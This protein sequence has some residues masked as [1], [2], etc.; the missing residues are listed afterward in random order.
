MTYPIDVEK[1]EDVLKWQDGQLTDW[2]QVLGSKLSIK[3]QEGSPERRG[4]NGAFSIDLFSVLRDLYLTQDEPNDQVLLHLNAIIDIL[5]DAPS[6][7]RTQSLNETVMIEGE[8]L[9]RQTSY[10]NTL[11]RLQEIR[12]TMT[13]ANPPYATPQ[14]I[15][16]L[17]VNIRELYQI[18]TQILAELTQNGLSDNFFR[19]IC[20]K[21]LAETHGAFVRSYTQAVQLARKFI[22][23]FDVYA[24]LSLLSASFQHPCKYKL[25]LER[26]YKFCNDEKKEKLNHIISQLNSLI[27]NVDSQIQYEDTF[28]TTITLADQYNLPVLLENNRRVCQT[29]E[30]KHY[31]NEL[32]MVDVSIILCNDILIIQSTNS[33]FSDRYPI[34]LDLLH[35]EIKVSGNGRL[36]VVLNLNPGIHDEYQHRTSLLHHYRMMKIRTARAVAWEHGIGRVRDILNKEM[37]CIPVSPK[38]LETNQVSVSEE[39]RIVDLGCSLL[40]VDQYSTYRLMIGVQDVKYSYWKKYSGSLSQSLRP[41][42][43][44]YFCEELNKL[45]LLGP[46]LRIW[47]LNEGRIEWEIPTPFEQLVVVGDSLLAFHERNKFFSVSNICLSDRHPSWKEKKSKDPPPYL[48]GS[49]AVRYSKYVL[50]IGGQNSDGQWMNTIHVYDILTK[51]WSLWYPFGPEEMP[52]FRHHQAEISGNFLYIILETFIYVLN[53]DTLFWCRL[54]HTIEEDQKVA[55]DGDGFLF[56]LQREDNG[57]ITLNRM[58][59][60]TTRIRSVEGDRKTSNPFA[61]PVSDIIDA[62]LKA[63]ETEDLYQ[64]FLMCFRLFCPAVTLMR[65]LFQ[66]HKRLVETYRK[67]ESFIGSQ[68]HGAEEV[69]TLTLHTQVCN[70]IKKWF[71]RFPSDFEIPEVK[72]MYETMC[73]TK[74]GNYRVEF[75]IVPREMNKIHSIRSRSMGYLPYQDQYRYSYEKVNVTNKLPSACVIDTT[76]ANQFAQQMAFNHFQLL[77]QIDLRNLI[78]GKEDHAL[79]VLSERSGQI[80]KWVERTLGGDNFDMKKGADQF[81]HLVRIGE[82]SRRVRDYHTLRSLITSMD[83]ILTR[84]G[85]REFQNKR[86]SDSGKTGKRKLSKKSSMAKILSKKVLL[87]FS[88]MSDLVWSDKALFQE[89]ES[90]P[91]PLIP[92]SSIIK[93]KLE[94]LSGHQFLN[95]GVNYGIC[96]NMTQFLRRIADSRSRDYEFDFDEIWDL[97][98][99]FFQF[100]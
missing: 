23:H 88:E 15:S 26:Y 45:L 7:P 86:F 75:L 66:R 73:N 20:R 36:L 37:L 28:R 30:G 90:A 91:L 71:R 96:R 5:D 70:L 55:P 92:P 74:I 16:C 60:D 44:C 21:E 2:L 17:F 47:S 38:Y 87:S 35:V 9:E 94:R 22:K 51:E 72:E 53:L 77:C 33:E 54:S 13:C 8:I 12:Q 81:E 18:H 84:T 65:N 52:P 62:V 25:L 63:D 64:T 24:Y 39:Y 56:R 10:V 1:S 46:R 100:D 95:K 78:A 6:T 34:I 80:R 99:Y 82:E 11:Q 98:S 4:V 31:T 49:K 58:V 40:V 68:R 76:D 29:G 79:N 97:G 42:E 93:L 32:G 89:M 61:A 85:V 43:K 67:D 3:C 57:Q 50:L 48:N 41:E 59:F 19:M 14:E 27:E 69:A 83:D